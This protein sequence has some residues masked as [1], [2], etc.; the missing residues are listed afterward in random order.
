VYSFKARGIVDFTP[1]DGTLAEAAIEAKIL[2]LGLCHTE[3]HCDLLCKHLTERVLHLMQR[4]G[5]PLYNP[6]CVQ[7]LQ[8]GHKRTGKVQATPD[9]KDAG[10]DKSSKEVKK[11][12]ADKKE[13]KQKIKKKAKKETEGESS[14]PAE[15]TEGEDEGSVHDG[16]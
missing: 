8:R 10:K 2:Y 5:S 1:G 13:K 11:S 14:P 3:S 12:K 16:E 4:E 6:L 15:D 7:E 9:R